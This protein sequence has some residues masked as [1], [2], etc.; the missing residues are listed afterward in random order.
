MG[1]SHPKSQALLERARQVMPGGVNK[2]SS[3]L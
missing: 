1:L 2:P 3:S